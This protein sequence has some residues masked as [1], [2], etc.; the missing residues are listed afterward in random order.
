M[1]AGVHRAKGG[2]LVVVVV[3]G[4]VVVVVVVVVIVLLVVVGV[5]M[6]GFREKTLKMMLMQQWST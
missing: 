2:V 3:V 6:T 1:L 4:V 5:E